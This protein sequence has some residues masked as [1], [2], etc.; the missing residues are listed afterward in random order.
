M[1]GRAV[2]RKFT[3]LDGPRTRALG[4]KGTIDIFDHAAEER[5]LLREPT[6]R[7]SGDCWRKAFR[8]G[9][10]PGD[11]EMTIWDFVRRIELQNFWDKSPRKWT[12]GSDCIPW[13]RFSGRDKLH[14][15]YMLCDQD[16]GDYHLEYVYHGKDHNVAREW[17]EAGWAAVHSTKI[18]TWYDEQMERQPELQARLIGQGGAKAALKDFKGTIHADAI[19]QE[20][21]NDVMRR[22]DEEK[23]LGYLDVS[24]ALVEMLEGEGVNVTS[25]GTISHAH[26][27]HKTME[28]NAYRNVYPPFMK[29][30]K[31]AVFFTKQAK[32][33][34]MRRLNPNVREL[35]NV[36][37]DHKDWGRYGNCQMP[38]H[39]DECDAIL[40]WDAG[41][42]LK[43]T[44]LAALFKR[45]PTIKR[46]YSAFVYAPE[47]ALHASSVYPNY[48]NLTYLPGGKVVYAMEGTEQGS[49]EQPAD[50][51]WLF[52][53]RTLEVKTPRWGM[54]LHHAML[55]SSLTHHLA[56]T[57]RTKPAVDR[58]SWTV[59]A[60]DMMKVPQPWLNEYQPDEHDGEQWVPRELYNNLLWYFTGLNPAKRTSQDVALKVRNLRASPKYAYIRPETWRLLMLST[61]AVGVVK[62]ECP[63]FNTM[64][65]GVLR[66]VFGTLVRKLREQNLPSPLSVAWTVAKFL[67]PM[68]LGTPWAAIYSVLRVSYRVQDSKSMTDFGLLLGEELLSHFLSN[69]TKAAIGMATG[70]WL[71]AVYAAKAVDWQE[72]K[73]R[74]EILAPHLRFL[75]HRHDQNW[76]FNGRLDAPFTVDPSAG[77]LDTL[78]NF[79]PTCEMCNMRSPTLRCESCST[80][81]K[82]GVSMHHLEVF[83]GF[84]CCRLQREAQKIEEQFQREQ[85]MLAD[86]RDLLKA[87]EAAQPVTREAEA[88]APVDHDP[89]PEEPASPPNPPA[90]PAPET[91][92]AEDSDEEFSDAATSIR[93]NATTPE[94]AGSPLD[95]EELQARLNKLIEEAKPR[96]PPATA[97]TTPKLRATLAALRDE[98]IDVHNPYPET[99]DEALSLGGCSF[100]S[101][102]SPSRTSSGSSAASA[103]WSDGNDHL[104]PGDDGLARLDTGPPPDDAEELSAY[105][106]TDNY[107]GPPKNRVPDTAP[108]LNDSNLPHSGSTCTVHNIKVPPTD[109]TKW[110][111]CKEGHGHWGDRDAPCHACKVAL[112]GQYHGV[113]VDLSGQIQIHEATTVDPSRVHFGNSPHF[114]VDRGSTVLGATPVTCLV[115]AIAE[116]LEVSEFVIWQA[117]CSILAPAYTTDLLPAP[118]LD[119]RFAHAVGLMLSIS[120]KLVGVPRGVPERVGLKGGKAIE[121]RLE[122]RD[123]VAHW[124]VGGKRLLIR[125]PTPSNV[126]PCEA[127]NGGHGGSRRPATRPPRTN[128]RENALAIWVN[129]AA[130]VL[131]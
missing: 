68:V 4:G 34:E 54:V 36:V 59:T 119:E 18:R 126:K 14:T 47:S 43:P 108:I 87:A 51:N 60:P 120:I 53:G 73:L 5:A 106:I 55:H 30:D 9:F 48:Y 25:Q 2:E 6:I 118:G 72:T 12:E 105:A 84:E 24:P 17:A 74:S 40:L 79:F 86:S 100:A 78:K 57:S 76:R 82:H 45:Y 104:V 101:R 27:A 99:E 117:G 93:T 22:L 15:Y 116:A 3:P 96:E 95:T 107:S 75:Y 49:Y 39:L 16:D 41:Q 83:A 102:S 91:S 114:R 109:G 131:S 20:M 42:F 123:G 121:L 44:N 63:S 38:D 10:Q 28:T 33:D 69:T 50:C 37:L 29:H 65:A 90:S 7:G 35:H 94:V 97:P 58:D 61:I 85:K 71:T 13:E 89:P 26:A 32:F 64:D 128:G 19:M 66:L 11:D 122:D 46:I 8:D 130:S 31:V 1:L 80:C 56:V 115:Q 88:A 129:V 124:S 52:E 62:A 92:S 70:C 112:V 110:E 113:S 98:D 21:V 67:F 103:V 23:A 127:R 111:P 77:I 81:A 125:S